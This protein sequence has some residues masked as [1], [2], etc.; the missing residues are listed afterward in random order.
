MRALA[1]IIGFGGSATTTVGGQGLVQALAQTAGRQNEQPGRAGRAGKTRAYRPE[2]AG[3]A[4]GGMPG[5]RW[6]AM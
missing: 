5:L 1:I 6:P 4:S 2:R 3:Q